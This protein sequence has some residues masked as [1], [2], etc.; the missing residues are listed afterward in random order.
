[1]AQTFIR[2]EDSKGTEILCLNLPEV[3]I[4]EITERISTTSYKGDISILSEL[5]LPLDFVSYSGALGD[6]LTQ[7]KLE[8][9]YKVSANLAENILWLSCKA[10]PSCSVSFEMVPL[11]SNPLFRTKNAKTV[12]ARLF[13][14]LLIK[15]DKLESAFRVYTDY[16]QEK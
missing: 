6:L 9:L 2:L 14:D 3:R 5:S 1:M 12:A 4:E 8:N 10:K 11:T 16:L 13:H 7:Y 15:M